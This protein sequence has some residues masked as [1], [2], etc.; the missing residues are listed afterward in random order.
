MK[1]MNLYF[2]MGLIMVSSLLSG[3][4]QEYRLTLEQARE[5]ALQHNKTLLN[6]RDKVLSADKKVKETIAQGLPQVEGSLDY[7]TYFNYEMEFNFGGGN[8]PNINYS[9]LDA[10]DLEVLNAI[11]QM[12]SSDPIIMSDQFSGKVQLTQL[13]FSGQFYAGIKIAKIARQL[14]DQ[15]LIIN[16]LD[17]K[18]NVSNTYCLI[19]TNEQTLKIINENLNNL[20]TIQQHTTNLYRAGVAEATDVDQIKITVSQ[21]KN[22]QKSLE[23]MNQLSYNML[24]FQLGVAP[25]TAIVLA[26]SLEQII[27]LINPQQAIITDY[28]IT[29]NI[30]YQLMESQVSLSE[31]QLNM[32]NWAYAPIIAGYYNYTEKFKTTGFD[33]N[34]N[35]VAGVSLSMP[36]FSS[37]MRRAKVSQAKIDLDIAQRNQEMVKDQ[38]QTQK[39]QL[40]FNYQNALENYNTQKENV[41]VANRVYKSIQ[42]KYEHG[43]ASSLDLTQANSNYLSAENNYL[44]SVMT[45][46]QAQTSLEKLYNTL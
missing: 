17:V 45:L 42:N 33:M 10:G 35:H 14:S 25:E 38:L 20:E 7:M 41:E 44:S 36:I 40:M 11:G 31:K 6:E 1:V 19:L 46:L 27:G 16:E 39:D 3:Q 34:P 13:I 5:Y 24:K 4:D 23:R 2:L 12:S 32:Q 22:T 26:D 37:G 43:L 28:D 29:S 21:L 15:S 9:V 30:N 8:Q 18:E